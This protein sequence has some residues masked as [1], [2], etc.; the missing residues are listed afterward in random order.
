MGRKSKPPVKI[1]SGN[2]DSEIRPLDGLPS[3][4]RFID[5][6]GKKHGQK[7]LTRL[8]FVS[9]SD[10]DVTDTVQKYQSKEIDV[11]VIGATMPYMKNRNTSPPLFEFCRASGFSEDFCIDIVRI[12]VGHLQRKHLGKNSVN[13]A[14]KSLRHFIGFL[15]TRTKRPITLTDI[16]KEDWA[17]YLERCAADSREVSEALFNTARQIFHA[18]PPTSIGG[19]LDGLMFK[20]GKRN[21]QLRE[22][23]SELAETKD[24]SDVVMYQLLSLFIYFFEQRIGYL[25]RYESLS[26]E[27]VPEDWIYPGRK[28]IVRNRGAGSDVAQLLYEWLCDDGVGYEILINHY[29]LHHKAESIGIKFK[30]RKES[31]FV[32]RLVDFYRNSKSNRALVSKFHEAMGHRFGY[33]PKGSLNPLSF[34]VNSKKA[35]TEANNV[36]NQIG[37]C[38][39]NLLMMQTGVNKEVVLTIPSK[40]ENGKSILTRCDTVFV[41]KDGT[42]TEINLY[43]IKARTGGSPEKI[44]PIII[45]KSSPLYEMLVDY[46]RYV[47]VGDGP[48]FE[49]NKTYILQWSTAGS[50]SYR[51]QKY[52]PVIDENGEKLTSIDST[53]FR[54]V[55]ASGQLL[56]RMKNIKDMNELAEKLRDDLNHGNLDTTLTH[57][58]LKSSV[59]RSVIDIA[60]ATVTGGKL[61][62]LKCQS[63]IQLRKQIQHKKK[64]FLCHC[65]DPHNPS[66]DVAIAE[67]C[68]HYDL[69]LGCEQSIISKE[70][71]PYICLRI[72]QYEAEREK[73]RLIW[74]AIFEDRWC[75]AHDAL[76]RYIEADRKNGRQIVDDAWSAAREGRISLPPII[77]PTRI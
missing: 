20:K 42:E 32:T 43:G 19:W 47:K 26:E 37:W 48:F 59:G 63:R 24:Y 4:K 62:D 75:I 18:Y 13:L 66:H 15:A 65:V 64:V 41:K 69:C 14:E 71:L 11:S 27:D 33:D 44:I 50:A 35:P 49:F 21:K 22:H 51:L 38:L 73:D 31:K 16:S 57:Y 12:A 7:V 70:H 60:I 68:R 8:F 2:S 30:N 23:T 39:A 5:V 9:P 77:A 46:E 45:A 74:A 40:A 54:K 6:V 58:L 72:L 67:E 56:D 36:I 3:F 28:A 17:D 25:K 55:F 10:D 34:H 53:R 76:A 1:E 52:F 61:N 29:I